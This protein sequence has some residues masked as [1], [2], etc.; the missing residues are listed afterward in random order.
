M[1][2]YNYSL[3]V[4]L[5]SFCILA[6]HFFVTVYVILSCIWLRTSECWVLCDATYWCL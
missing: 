3:E 5:M 1:L 2:I 6:L 4:I